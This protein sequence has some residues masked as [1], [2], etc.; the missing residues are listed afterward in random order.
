[1]PEQPQTQANQ[2]GW[3]VVNI[4]DAPASP[5]PSTTQQN[6]LPKQPTSPQPDD[7]WAVTG[8]S[9]VPV[10]GGEQINDVGNKVIV[11]GEGES[12]DD[13]MKRAAAYGKTVTQDQLNREEKTIPGKAATVLAAAPVIGAAGTAAGAAINEAATALPS[14]IPHTIAGVKAIGAWANANPI[15]AYLL[16]NLLK[17]MVPGAKKAIGLIKGMPEE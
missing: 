7:Q 8:I 3:D 4:S 17:E 1:M 6:S 9:D 16:Y 5:S 14:V 15:Q 2:N 10:K 11:P 13:T 12:F